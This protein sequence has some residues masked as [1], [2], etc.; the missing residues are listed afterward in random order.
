[1]GLTTEGRSW[2]GL[3]GGLLG[4]AGMI[5]G[6]NWD[7]FFPPS[8]QD[9]PRIEDQE[10]AVA[11]PIPPVTSTGFGSWEKLQPDVTYKAESDGFVAAYTGGNRPAANITFL[12]G[13]TPGDVTTRTRASNWDGSVCPVPKGHYWRVQRR[14]GRG[15][16]TVYWLPLVSAVGEVVSSE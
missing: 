15:T 13:P 6:H 5:L 14:D 16:A 7:R 9:P 11:T 8:D 4:F 10:K 12:A 1:M 3:I 2:V